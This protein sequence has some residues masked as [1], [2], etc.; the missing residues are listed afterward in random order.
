MLS[1]QRTTYLDWDTQ[2]SLFKRY[3]HFCHRLKLSDY[4]SLQWLQQT[5]FISDSTSVAQNPYHR[6][7]V[8]SAGN[9]HPIEIYVQLR[10]IAGILS[11]IYHLDVLKRELVMIMEIAGEGIEPYMGLEHRFNGALV[12]ISLVPFRSSWKY[13]LRGWRYLYLD[14]G[15]QIGALSTSVHHFGYKL[16]KMSPP[17]RFEYHYGIWRG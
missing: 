15:H 6:L 2:P 9:L 5:R 8:P 11:G 4:P 17:K 12:M 14:L 7:N 16:T 13:G 3:P 1:L 10:N